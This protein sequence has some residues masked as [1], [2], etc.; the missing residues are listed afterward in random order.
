M[1]LPI[2]TIIKKDCIK[3]LKELPERSVDL[4]IADPPYF[5]T[6]NQKWDYEWRTEEDYLEW[7]EKWIKE[8][9][10]VVKLGSSFYLFG[11]FRVFKDYF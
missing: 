8:L 9:S 7:T 10:R 11:Y 1:S 6:V 5:K 4:V 3:G 2:N